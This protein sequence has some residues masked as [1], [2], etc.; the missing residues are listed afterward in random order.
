MEEQMN[1]D[2]IQYLFAVHNGMEERNLMTPGISEVMLAPIK[3]WVSEIGPSEGVL[4][5]LLRDGAPEPIKIFLEEKSF[6]A[7]TNLVEKLESMILLYNEYNS[8]FG[9]VIVALN[10][11]AKEIAESYPQQEVNKR[12]LELPD[13]P[14]K[15]WL[16]KLFMDLF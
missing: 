3:L 9:Q 4:K 13:M 12:I 8:G 5:K 16:K 10:R 1:L 7:S 14:L 15:K 6:D 2:D 11:Q